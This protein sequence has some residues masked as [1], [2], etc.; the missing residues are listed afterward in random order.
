[1]S[2]SDTDGRLLMVN[3]TAADVSDSVGAQLIL[4]GIRKRWG[5][6]LRP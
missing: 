1:M 6:R 2:L 4:D 5:A 3:L